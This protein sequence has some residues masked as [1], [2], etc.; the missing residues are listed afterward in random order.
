MTT[1]KNPPIMDTPTHYTSGGREYFTFYDGRN[2]QRVAFKSGDTWYWLSNALQNDLS[3]RTLEEI[4]KSMRPLSRARLVKGKRD[5][6][7]AVSTDASTR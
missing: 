2:L 5:T 7:I 4:A 6:A 1:M 3:A